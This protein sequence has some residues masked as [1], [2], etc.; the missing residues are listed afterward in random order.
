V[1]AE[2]SNRDETVRCGELYLCMK[3]QEVVGSPGE[4]YGRRLPNTITTVIFFC[5]AIWRLMTKDTDPVNRKASVKA[6]KAVINVH[7]ADCENV[8]AG[9]GRVGVAGSLTRPEH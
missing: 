2:D 1:E 4:A 7:R 9:Q 3:E 8:R 6:F 5:I